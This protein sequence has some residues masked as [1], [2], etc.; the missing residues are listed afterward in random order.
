M[1]KSKGNTID[2]LDLIDGIALEDLVAKS[3]VGLLRAEHKQ[4]IEET[5]RKSY[6]DGIPGFGADAMRFTFASLA[7]FARTLLVDLNR[8]EGYRSFCNKLWNASRF[9]L[10]NCEGQGCGLRNHPVDEW[11]RGGCLGFTPS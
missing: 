6:P 9:V 5:I 4:K 8:C 11:G 10:M 2:P 3:T 1:S 7:P